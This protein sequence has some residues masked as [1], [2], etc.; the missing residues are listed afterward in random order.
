MHG[1]WHNQTRPLSSPFHSWRPRPPA[2]PAAAMTALDHQPHHHPTPHLLGSKTPPATPTATPPDP[3]P[4]RRPTSQQR[5]TFLAANTA[6]S[7]SW[8]SLRERSRRATLAAATRPSLIRAESFTCAACTRPL[9]CGEEGAAA[10]AAESRVP[11]QARTGSIW[12]M[13]AFH[14]QG[15][16]AEQRHR[17]DAST[18]PSAVPDCELLQETMPDQCWHASARTIPVVHLQHS[19]RRQTTGRD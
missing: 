11:Q 9:A 8:L 3:Q 18:Q 19:R 4:H 14:P 7:T 16:S 10:G 2:T 13:S 1:T 17:S 12:C 6:S 15:D 5:P